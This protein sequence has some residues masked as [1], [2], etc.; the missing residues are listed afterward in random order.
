MKEGKKQG[1]MADSVTRICQYCGKEFT[2]YRSNKRIC[3]EECRKI[4]NRDYNREY[5][6]KHPMYQPEYRKLHYVYIPK[7]RCRICGELIY[8][9][10]NGH[11]RNRARFHTE[12]LIRDAVEKIRKNE[13]IPSHTYERLSTR[14]ISMKDIYQL[15]AEGEYVAEKN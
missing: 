3:S 1:D 15:L 11:C 10:Y 8:Q 6:K 5:R 12:C 13:K 4:L 7:A 14:G 9:E 2:T